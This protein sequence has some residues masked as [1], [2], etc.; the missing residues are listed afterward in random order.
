[1]QL[2]QFNASTM[3][4]TS[5]KTAPCLKLTSAS[6]RL[7]SLVNDRYRATNPSIAM[8]APGYLPTKDEANLE[9]LQ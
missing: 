8:A 2:N 5:Y 6:G 1:M 3:N 4:Y 7:L 9:T